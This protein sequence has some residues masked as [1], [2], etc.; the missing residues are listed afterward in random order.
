MTHYPAELKALRNWIVWRLEAVEGREKPAKVPYSVHGGRAKTNDAATWATFDEAQ[1]FALAKGHNGVGFVFTGTPYTG[2]DLDGAI[3]ADGRLGE[4]SQSIIAAFPGAHVERSQS[5]LGIHIIV[6]GRLPAGGRRKGP[7]EAYDADSPRYFALTGDT[8]DF[9]QA[10]AIPEANGAL[11]A[12]HTRWIGGVPSPDLA[13]ATA[14]VSEAAIATLVARVRASRKGR[15]FFSLWDM[16]ERREDRQSEADYEAASMLWGAVA[17]LDLSGATAEDVV[18]AAMAAS[19]GLA[20]KKWQEQRAG[21][22]LLRY[23][24]RHART[25]GGVGLSGEAPTF[26]W[27]YEGELEHETEPGWLMP[28]VLPSGALAVLFGKSSGGKSFL[29]LDWAM[30]L[31]VRGVHVAYVAAEGWAGTKRRRR[32]WRIANQVPTDRQLPATFMSGNVNLMDEAAVAAF[33]SSTREKAEKRGLSDP[34]LIV[35]DTLNQNM[36]G[37]DENQ[38]ADMT[39]VIGSVNYLRRETG[40][41]IL[42]IHHPRKADEVERGHSSLGNAA[43]TML[44]LSV[45]DANDQ[46]VL[47]Q[48]KQKDAAPI[49]GIRYALVPVM[50]PDNP[51][52]EVSLVMQSTTRGAAPPTEVPAGSRPAAV[53]DLFVPGRLVRNADVQTQLKT[54]FGLA[55][56]A[57]K[58]AARRCLNALV[59]DYRRLLKVTGGYRLLTDQE[60]ADA[61]AQAAST[62]AAQDAN[63]A[64]YGGSNE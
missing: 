51:A 25:G 4:N 39:A 31:A 36:P 5:L 9:R 35:I 30:R 37:G 50:D 7:V 16:G 57:A 28:G 48:T 15:R 56:D 27:L 6:K 33:V 55:E 24:V 22:S 8:W 29:A 34:A 45:D 42:L 19:P 18:V 13:P 17:G 47:D 59:E 20:R 14:D 54:M 53:L 2:I 11:A 62:Q 40:A 12:F 64:H 52:R 60:R 63:E 38:A 23:T 49:S 10:D 32:A 46:R 61:L 58:Q 41:T 21:M 44:R 43:D 1:A 26:R 3:G